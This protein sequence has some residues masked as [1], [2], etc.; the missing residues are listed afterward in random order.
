MRELVAEI[1]DLLCAQGDTNLHYVDGMSLLGPEDVHL[2]S[3]DGIHPGA[4]GCRFLA[5]AYADKVMPLLGM[6]D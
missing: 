6:S 3:D 2:F 1:C 4:E 5:H